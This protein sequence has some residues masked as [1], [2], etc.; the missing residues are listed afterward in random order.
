MTTHKGCGNIELLGIPCL[1][2]SCSKTDFKLSDKIEENGEHLREPYEVVPTKDVK[3]FIRLRNRL[4]SDLCLL[5][6]GRLHSGVM[7][8]NILIDLVKK[9]FKE[10]QDEKDKLAGDLE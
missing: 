10:H 1:C 6:M 7:D 4:D 3:T 2:L 5:I 8:M 9:D